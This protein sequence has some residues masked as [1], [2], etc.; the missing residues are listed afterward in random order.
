MR[1]KPIFAGPRCGRDRGGKVVVVAGIVVVV[2]STGAMVSGIDVSE[3]SAFTSDVGTRTHAT[4]TVRAMRSGGFIVR[5]R[6]TVK[7]I[8][9][10]S[11]RY[12]AAI[13]RASAS[14]FHDRTAHLM[15]TGNFTTPCRAS[16]SPRGV[17][18]SGSSPP[19]S[20]D[21]MCLKR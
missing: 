7:R 20:I 3:P 11:M 17:D 8:A 14:V 15:R 4:R 5:E 16:R 2:G 21:I 9:E 19:S 1:A 13:S 6:L 12:S 18:V 10:W